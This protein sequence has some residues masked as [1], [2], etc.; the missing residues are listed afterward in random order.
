MLAVCCNAHEFEHD[1]G[2]GSTY[3]AGG[4]LTNGDGVEDVRPEI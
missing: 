3:T 4:I 1:M 2:L